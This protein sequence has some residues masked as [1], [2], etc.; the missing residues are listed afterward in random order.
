LK[1]A[2][3]HYEIFCRHHKD[4]LFEDPAFGELKG[5]DAKNMWR[6]LVERSKGEIQITFKD[7]E[8]DAN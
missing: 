4:I 5:D 2:T 1:K 7:I 3:S 6:M 8:A